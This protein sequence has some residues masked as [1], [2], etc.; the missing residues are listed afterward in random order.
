MLTVRTLRE[1]ASVVSVAWLIGAALCMLSVLYA[2]ANVYAPLG[3]SIDFFNSTPWL[4]TLPIPM[5]V[6]VASTGTI[7]WM[8]S[9]L[10]PVSIIERR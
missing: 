5:A 6:V 1:S 8:L 3:L 9:R 4:F 7:A 10:D 2:Q